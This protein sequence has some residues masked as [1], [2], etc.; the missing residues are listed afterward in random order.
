LEIDHVQWRQAL[1]D[2]FGGGFVPVLFILSTAR[3]PL[4]VS[5]SLQRLRDRLLIL[6]TTTDIHSQEESSSVSPFSTQAQ[7]VLIPNMG[8]IS[9]GTMT[10]YRK[11]MA[12]SY[13]AC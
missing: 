10:A 2:V 11:V 4:K 1:L 8:K 5:A 6:L 3:T 12:L 9:T 7:I 13:L